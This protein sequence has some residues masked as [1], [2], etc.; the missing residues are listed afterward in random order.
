MHPLK[1][2]RQLVRHAACNQSQEFVDALAPC[3]RLAEEIQDGIAELLAVVAPPCHLVHALG[4]AVDCRERMRG[5][6][7]EELAQ[8]QEIF[9]LVLR[10]MLLADVRRDDVEDGNA[11]DADSAEWRYEGCWRAD[12][13][14]SHVWDARMCG[15]DLVP[16]LAS[17]E[18]LARI[19]TP[20]SKARGMNG[21]YGACDLRS[22][23]RGCQTVAY[24]I[25]GLCEAARR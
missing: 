10:E 17:E 9:L 14:S 19:Q 21:L 7:Q 13:Q 18:N 2:S 3:A 1:A 24:A 6:T 5:Q 12:S 20:H 16:V 4:D 22:A 8:G 15:R 25:R 11:V 23:G